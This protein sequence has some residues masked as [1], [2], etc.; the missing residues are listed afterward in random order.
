MKT[1]SHQWHDT[2]SKSRIAR[3]TTGSPAPWRIQLTQ[4]RNDPAHDSTRNTS[5]LLTGDTAAQRSTRSR[6]RNVSA[7]ASMPHQHMIRPDSPVPSQASSYQLAAQMTRLSLVHSG[8]AQIWTPAARTNSSRLPVVRPDRASSHAD[9]PA[10]LYLEAMIAAGDNYP[11]L[12]KADDLPDILDTSRVGNWA[13]RKPQKVA[14]TT[15]WRTGNIP[16]T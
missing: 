11:P 16:T 2:T 10:S 14:K 5:N 3:R 6:R 9:A 12:I 1:L 7:C 13:R 15:T 8:S 4:L